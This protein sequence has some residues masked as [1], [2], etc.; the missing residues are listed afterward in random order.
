MQ[1]YS[2]ILTCIKACE[3]ARD[4]CVVYR[5]TAPPHLRLLFCQV[6]DLRIGCIVN[7]TVSGA[8]EE[9]RVCTRLCNDLCA[10]LQRGNHSAKV[11][12]RTIYWLS[13]VISFRVANTHSSAHTII[14][15]TYWRCVCVFHGLRTH[16]TR[17]SISW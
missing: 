7:Q 16:H 17:E 13:S 3:Q 15:L 5:T 6:V 8:A 1:L 10:P 9:T 4:C 11:M 12:L 14:L 2:R